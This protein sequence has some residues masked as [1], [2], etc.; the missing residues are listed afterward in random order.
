MGVFIRVEVVEA[1]LDAS[2]GRALAA[3]CPVDIFALEGERL[4]VVPEREDECT[5]CELC[6][7]AAPTGAI[8]IHKLYSDGCLRSRGPAGAPA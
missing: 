8:A 6:L 2:L 5:L 4:T 1:Q 3:M 7:D